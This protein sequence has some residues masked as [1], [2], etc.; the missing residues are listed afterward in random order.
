MDDMGYFVS[1]DCRKKA[2]VLSEGLGACWILS[3]W[4]ATVS[5]DH[6]GWFYNPSCCLSHYRSTL[7]GWFS[8]DPHGWSPGTHV[9]WLQKNPLLVAING[10]LPHSCLISLEFDRVRQYHVLISDASACLFLPRG[11]WRVERSSRS[12]RIRSLFQVYL[13]SWETFSA[14]D[15]AACSPHACKDLE[16][17]AW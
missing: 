5:H 4:T 9:V 3:G 1:L 8:E 6:C 12:G 11:I 16:G 13:R 17:R 15:Y 10:V 7:I 2:W 14:W